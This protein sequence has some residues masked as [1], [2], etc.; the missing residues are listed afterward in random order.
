MNVPVIQD[1]EG[2][3][4]IQQPTMSNVYQG[5]VC[6][7]YWRYWWWGCTNEL[8]FVINRQTSCNCIWQVYE[9]VKFWSINLPRKML[10]PLRNN[11][12]WSTLL[13]SLCHATPVTPSSVLVGWFFYSIFQASANGRRGVCRKRLFSSDWPCNESSDLYLTYAMLS[14]NLYPIPW[15]LSDW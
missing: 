2:L 1:R 15:F 7:H 4:Y 8:Y 10:P 13:M 11:N 12:L 3:A 9:R 6:S 5:C 14:K